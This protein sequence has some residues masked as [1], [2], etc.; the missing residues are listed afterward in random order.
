MALLHAGERILYRRQRLA[1]T[2]ALCG[3]DFSSAWV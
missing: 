2:G 1:G 3:F